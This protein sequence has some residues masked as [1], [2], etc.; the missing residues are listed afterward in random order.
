MLQVLITL[1]GIAGLLLFWCVAWFALAWLIGVGLR[2]A[3]LVG[4]RG[5]K[6]RPLAGRQPI[7]TQS[8]KLRSPT[9]SN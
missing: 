1:A 7:E 9:Q 4:R 5:R 6:G 2:F 3:P 8:S